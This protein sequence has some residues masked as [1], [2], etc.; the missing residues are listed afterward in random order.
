MNIKA[1]LTLSFRQ[2]K[3]WNTDALA[4]DLEKN[5][6]EVYDVKLQLNNPDCCH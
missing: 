6:C 3:G 5:G 1:I 2:R 4:K